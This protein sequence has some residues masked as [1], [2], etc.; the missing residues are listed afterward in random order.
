MSFSVEA[1]PGGES[2]AALQVIPLP[3]DRP[4]PSDQPLVVV[5]LA[6]A[7]AGG[8]ASASSP[9]TE[10]RL[11][12]AELAPVPT[13]VS[14]T[15]RPVL[16]LET[17]EE[18]DEKEQAAATYARVSDFLVSPAAEPGPFRPIDDRPIDVLARLSAG[19]G[20]GVGASVGGGHCPPR[21][22]LP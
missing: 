21:D 8:A 4:E 20:S 19:R 3:E 14:G 9:I 17:L 1:M 7:F 12:I 18:E 5:E 13:V 22:A 2:G 10:S 16:H 11:P 15:P 6:D